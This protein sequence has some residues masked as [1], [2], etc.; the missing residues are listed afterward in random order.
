[1]SQKNPFKN[2]S[3][4]TFGRI[5]STGLQAGFYLIF[6]VILGPESFGQLSY[7]V[8]LAGT[9]SIVSRIGLSHTVVVYQAKEN[10]NAVNQA[11]V[12]S[13]ITTGIAA[14]LLI[15][16][17]IYAALLCLSLSMFTM[18]LQNSLGQKRYKKYFWIIVIKSG[19]IITIP[20]LLYF[21][22]DIPG[23]LLGMAISNFIMGFNFLK[24]LNPKIHSFKYLRQN[25]RVL[26]HN[27]GVESS[28]GLTRWV[29]KLLIVPLFGFIFAGLYQFNIQI[30]F[31]L[32]LLPISLHSFLLAEESSG[33]SHKKISFII[34]LSSILLVFITII[35]APYVIPQYFPKY[36]DGISSL[37]ILIVS[38]IPFTIAAIFNA[39]L[40]A[41]ES[42]KVGF[43]GLT[44]ITSLLFFIAIL[45]NWYGLLGLSLAVLFSS[46]SETIFLS[47][48]FFRTKYGLS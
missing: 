1:L 35:F 21:P 40:Q 28:I 27:F 3:L 29:D 17:N 32:T 6:A 13:L 4:V 38:L 23:I 44:R 41:K 16:I 43:A 45:G 8:A 22:L 14:I 9:V 20:I 2:F 24:L 34:I 33:T 46:I 18:N 26:I 48:L 5:I 30:L 37:Q 7:L 25:F 12:L 15:P 11:N 36:Q 19:L 47:L 42:T 10:T 31:A 39:K